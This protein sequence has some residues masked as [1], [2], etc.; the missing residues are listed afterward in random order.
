M[1]DLQKDLENN[2]QVDSLINYLVFYSKGMAPV[3]R[4]CISHTQVFRVMID[5]VSFFDYDLLEHLITKFGS[6]SIKEDL[7]KYI[8]SF[9]AF[10][11]R[12]V[13]ECPTDAFGG[14][15]ES[16]KIFVLVSDKIIEDLTLDGLKKFKLR[17]DMILGNELVK[18]LSI[19][20]GSIKITFKTFMDRCDLTK[21]QQR[22]LRKE[23]IVSVY[24]GDQCI[25]LLKQGKI[26]S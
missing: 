21:E 18:I 14:V 17:I 2:L 23:G 10:S 3:L 26:Y 15:E 4:D 12:L 22:D 9:E 24:Y 5:F 19:E 16:D 7:K 13:I 6:N 20:G 1:F 25:N 11:K 8:V